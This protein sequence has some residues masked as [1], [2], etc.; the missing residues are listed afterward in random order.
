MEEKALETIKEMLVAR[1]LKGDKFEAVGSPLEE[2]NMY[3]FDGLLIIFSMKA[4]V[5]DKE[6]TNCI[7]YASENNHNNGVIIVSPSRASDAVLS[8]LREYIS[9]KSNNLV[10]FFEIRHLQFNISKHV[11]VPFH[12]IISSDELERVLK[13]TNAVSPKMFSKI[14]CQD[15]MARWIG[16]RPGDVL[17]IRGMCESSVENKRY[18]YCMADVTN[19]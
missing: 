19:G 2:T 13:D 18:R 9:D 12:R 6:L 8:S 11:K 7:Q 17:E 3:T 10:Q 1:G 4:R 15:P 14:D 16:A 5:T